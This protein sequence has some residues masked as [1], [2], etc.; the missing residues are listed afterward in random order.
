MIIDSFS[1]IL[2]TN[3]GVFWISGSSLGSG[4]FS[5]FWS[6]GRIESGGGNE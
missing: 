6:F 1:M 3:Y 4:T 5:E 2:Q